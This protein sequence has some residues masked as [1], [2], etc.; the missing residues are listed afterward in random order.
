MNCEELFQ[1]FLNST[2]KN[3]EF[4]C[5]NATNNSDNDIC[6]FK[7]FKCN[8]TKDSRNNIISNLNKKSIIKTIGIEFDINDFPS[9][10][11]IED[12]FKINLD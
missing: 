6:Y 3:K 8:L 5:Y 12:G 10:L 4:C 11:N 1:Q 2:L 9:S 7:N